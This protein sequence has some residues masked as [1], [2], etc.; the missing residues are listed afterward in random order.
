MGCRDRVSLL[1]SK[2]ILLR[3]AG[4]VVLDFA[5]ITIAALLWMFL[6]ILIWEAEVMEIQWS[7]AGCMGIQWSDYRFMEMYAD[8]IPWEKTDVREWRSIRHK[9]M[10]LFDLDV[11]WGSDWY[12]AKKN[13]RLL[14][15]AVWFF[16]WHLNREWYWL[17]FLVVSSYELLARL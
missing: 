3:V 15:Q 2:N 9:P 6:E 13:G 14:R 5:F 7:E 1:N 12:T 8:S 16:L 17:Y 4:Y 11:L 10:L